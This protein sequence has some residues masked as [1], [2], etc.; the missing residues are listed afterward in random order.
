MTN[1]D[2]LLGQMIID[3]R[4][5]ILRAIRENRDENRRGIQHLSRRMT[6]ERS[7]GT[8][9]DI[10]AM[11]K[12]LLRAAQMSI[13]FLTFYFTGSLEKALQWASLL[14]K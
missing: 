5:I 3:S 13:G 9:P 4:Q 8:G 10:T 11:E 6:M 14:A 12:W 1:S 7:R 2:I